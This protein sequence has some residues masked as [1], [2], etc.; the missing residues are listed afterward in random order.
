MRCGVF[1][2]ADAGD[3]GRGGAGEVELD[4]AEADA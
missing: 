1:G 4:E 2:V 3:D